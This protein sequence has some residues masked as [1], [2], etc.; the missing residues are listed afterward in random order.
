MELPIFIIAMSGL[1]WFTHKLVTNYPV[2]PTPLGFYSAAA[3]KEL[4]EA[5][6][7]LDPIPA[8]FELSLREKMIW[9]DLTSSYEL[10]E[11]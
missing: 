8:T 9:D 7:P 1:I 4:S 10:E 5:P 3:D 2:M 6:A 11:D